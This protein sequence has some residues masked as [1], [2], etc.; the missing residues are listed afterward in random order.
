MCKNIDNSLFHQDL[1]DLKV[2][3]IVPH[4][5][6]EINTAGALTDILTSCGATMKLV[7]TTNEDWKYPAS[8]RMKEAI[9]AASVLGIRSKDIIFLGYGDSINN[10]DRNHLF[11]ADKVYTKSP[12]GYSETYGTELFSDYSYT[13]N[14]CHHEYI[15]QNYLDDIISVLRNERPD[16]IICTDFDEHPDHRMLSLYLSG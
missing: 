9:E 1:K 8:T 12:A 6:D 13:I 2:L 7:Y 10:N 4:E 16:M 3:L 11:Y 5:D 14:G 15:R